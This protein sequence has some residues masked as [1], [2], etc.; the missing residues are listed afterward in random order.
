MPAKDRNQ[1]YELKGSNICPFHRGA[2]KHSLRCEGYS[3]NSVLCRNWGDPAEKK[4]WQKKHCQ[5]GGKS[6]PVYKS[7]MLNKYTQRESIDNAI[8]ILE[9][10]P[11]E[12]PDEFIENAVELCLEFLKGAGE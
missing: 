12:Y 9:A 11:K 1:W 8:K 10:L 7:I 5:T 3:E 4:E 6:C 2:K